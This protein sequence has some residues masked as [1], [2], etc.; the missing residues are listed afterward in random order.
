MYLPSHF[1]QRDPAALRALMREHPLAMVVTAA[2]EGLTADHLPLELEVAGDALRLR[3]HVARANP[4]WRHADG[5]EV[6]AVFRGPQAYVTPSW[7]P[8]KAEHHKV[9]PTWNYAVVHAHGVLRAIDDAPWLRELVGRLTDHQESARA[10][11]WAV[12]DAP[13]DYVQ[14]MLR[15]IVGIEIEVSRCVGK[16]KVSQ[17]RSAADRAGV[18]SGLASE[19]AEAAQRMARLVR[20]D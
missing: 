17:N 19:T 15:A 8:A 13:A 10:T 5:R 12:D 18:A 20:G 14:Q 7:Y 16:W 3:G 11:P 6:L 4:L 9:V 2:S 1:E